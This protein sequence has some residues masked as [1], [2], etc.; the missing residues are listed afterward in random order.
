[1]TIVIAEDNPEI[2]ELYRD[3]FGR[4]YS[5]L[6]LVTTAEEALNQFEKGNVRLL[7]TDGHFGNGMDGHQ[8]TDRVRKIGYEGPIIMVSGTHS[9]HR[10]DVHYMGKPIR[11]RDLLSKVGELYTQ[12]Q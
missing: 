9:N 4:K 1:M 11:F 8:L 5:K 10:N 3:F 12:V 6:T 7:V 2:L